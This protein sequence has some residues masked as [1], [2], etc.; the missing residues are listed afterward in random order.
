MLLQCFCMVWGLALAADRQRINRFIQ[1]TVKVDYLLP[2]QP[3]AET[4]DKDAENHMLTSVKPSSLPC[5][6]TT[7]SRVITIDVL[8]CVPARMIFFAIIRTIITII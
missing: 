7:F 8:I 2:G 5:S 6:W 4:L 1:P 3:D